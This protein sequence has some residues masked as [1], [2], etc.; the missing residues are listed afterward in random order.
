MIMNTFPTF[1]VAYGINTCT[2]HINLNWSLSYLRGFVV[3]RIRNVFG[4]D[5]NVDIELILNTGKC[6][7]ELGEPL[8]DTQHIT[9]ADYYSDQRVRENLGENLDQSFYIR[10][11][12]KIEETK[13]LCTDCHFE[14]HPDSISP[15]FYIPMA[16]LEEFREGFKQLADIQ[17]LTQ[18]EFLGRMSR[19]TP[20]LGVQP[21]PPTSSCPICLVEV[22]ESHCYYLC[23]HVFCARCFFEWHNINRSC[24]LCRSNE[25]IVSENL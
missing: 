7:A 23:N 6:F 17:I 16:D 14:R 25:T 12:Y 20:Q 24:P 9:I 1:K 15:K 19:E 18:S 10:A 3:P 22:N 4:F 2:M 11:I 8:P 13:Y 5:G 21:L